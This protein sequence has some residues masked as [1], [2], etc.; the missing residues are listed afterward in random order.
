MSD[1]NGP[2]LA[3]RFAAEVGPER[4]RRLWLEVLETLQA[5]PRWCHDLVDLPKMPTTVGRQPNPFLSLP[6]LANPNPALAS[7]L[8]GSWDDFYAAKRSASTRKRERRQLKQLAQHG[9][10]RFV[11]PRTQAEI[12]V[13]LDTMLGQKARSF[14]RMGVD[15]I[16]GRPGHRDFMLD[17]L[18]DDD[19][20][21]VVHLTRLDVGD[22]TGAASLGLRFRGCYYLILSS[23]HDGEIS[24]CG[25]GRA[26]LHELLSRTM[27]AGC[28]RFDFT[29]G[30]ESYK[31]DWADIELSVLRSPVGRHAARL[32]HGRGPRG[33]APRQAR[34]QA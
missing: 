6:V 32:V 17:L 21:D 18:M 2:L 14:A 16:F 26:H 28:D 3:P 29:I 13:T 27:D 34:D 1:Y 25:P 33:G 12:A 24:R 31:R 9:E 5:D 11:E 15:N 19:L 4:F 30:E 22:T 8:R 23:Y 20:R 10:V 7:A